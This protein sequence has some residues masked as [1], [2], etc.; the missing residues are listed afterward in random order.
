MPLLVLY[1][2]DE[3]VVPVEASAEVIGRT[4]R[5]DLL[6][7]AVLPG[8]DHRLQHGDPP[9]LVPELEPAIARF[10]DQVL[11]REERQA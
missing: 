11:G 2:E 3:R 8:G 6:T 9:A 4:V 10:L 5:P 7:L 1:G